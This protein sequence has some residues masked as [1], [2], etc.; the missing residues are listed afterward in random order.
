MSCAIVLG[1]SCHA[2][3]PKCGRRVAF[4]SGEEHSSMSEEKFFVSDAVVKLVCPVHGTF[5]VSAGEFYD[6]LAA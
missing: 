4:F 5:D 3:C 6:E 2:G 1:A